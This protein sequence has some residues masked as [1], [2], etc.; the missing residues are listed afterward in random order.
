MCVA[1]QLF[2][3]AVFEA[4]YAAAVGA[5]PYDAIF[6]GNGCYGSEVGRIAFVYLNAQECEVFFGVAG[7]TAA[8]L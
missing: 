8:L 1:Y 7:G 6:A 4:Y 5:G 3:A 2:D